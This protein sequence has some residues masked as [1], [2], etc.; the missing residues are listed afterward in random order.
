MLQ[1]LS[2]PEVGPSAGLEGPSVSHTSKHC[3]YL[4]LPAP[5]GNPELPCNQGLGGNVDAACAV[6]PRRQGNFWSVATS[7]HSGQHHWPQPPLFG[8][9]LSTGMDSMLLRL[10]E[11]VYLIKMIPFVLDGSTFI[12]LSFIHSLQGPTCWHSWLLRSV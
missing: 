4:P 12:L 5:K 7:Q 2:L 9:L 1:T 8:D 3:S 11:I 10:L 6:P